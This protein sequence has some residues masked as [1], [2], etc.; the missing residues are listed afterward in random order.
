MFR[1]FPVY[2][3]EYKL[4]RFIYLNSLDSIRG[5]ILQSD[6]EVIVRELNQTSFLESRLILFILSI[7]KFKMLIF[8]LFV[9]PI[10]LTLSQLSY[11]EPCIWCSTGEIHMGFLLLSNIM[12][13]FISLYKPQFAVGLLFG[14]I[15]TWFYFF[16]YVWI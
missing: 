11:G 5:D 9:T 15:F 13:F 10:L 8:G 2:N 6:P 16:E 7:S 1:R 3:D 4:T 12:L 14:S